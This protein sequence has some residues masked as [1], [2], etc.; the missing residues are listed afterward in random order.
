MPH[1]FY[2]ILPVKRNQ[3]RPQN[4]L[5]PA[6]QARQW[7][8]FPPSARQENP[9][10]WCPPTD[11]TSQEWQVAAS[12]FSK[13]GSACQSVF[14]NPRQSHIRKTRQRQISRYVS[15]RE[16]ISL[17]KSAAVDGRCLC[18]FSFFFSFILLKMIFT[19]F[20]GFVGLNLNSLPRTC[21]LSVILMFEA[22]FMFVILKVNQSTYF[23]MSWFISLIGTNCSNWYAL[24]TRYNTSS[25]ISDLSIRER[26]RPHTTS[27]R[28][29]LLLGRRLI[30]AF[31]CRLQWRQKL[32][33][34]HVW[35]HLLGIFVA[36]K[37]LR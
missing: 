21:D 4:K 19:M 36:N 20:I 29:G 37:R 27:E 2:P 16:T 31:G 11:A 1:T 24:I 15:S 5:F 25:I 23:Q 35:K 18:L 33:L 22:A 17:L 10:E 13:D 6:Y 32:Y 9:P 34:C 14:L 28:L 26:W 30:H 3:L 8:Q 7:R 12:A